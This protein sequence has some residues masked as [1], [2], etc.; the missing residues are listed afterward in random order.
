V[1]RRSAKTLIA[2]A[3]T[4]YKGAVQLAKASDD[5]DVEEEAEQRGLVAREIA[6]L[7]YGGEVQGERAADGLME[8]LEE[9]VDEGIVCQRLAGAIMEG[10]GG[11]SGS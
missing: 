10:G 4:F 11:A 3:Q 6:A 1:V 9:C 7:L 5:E 8:I 2:N